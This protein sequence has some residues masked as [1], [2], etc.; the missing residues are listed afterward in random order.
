M[1]TET[2]PPPT[3][4][5]PRLCT[6]TEANLSK[7]EM[8]GETQNESFPRSEAGSSYRDAFCYFVTIPVPGGSIN[9]DYVGLAVPR[10]DTQ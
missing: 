7:D 1:C 4:Q 5:R 3:K 6:E 2:V 8:G 9:Y 10:L